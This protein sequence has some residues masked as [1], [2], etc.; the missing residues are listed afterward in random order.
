MLWPKVLG[1]LHKTHTCIII[2]V[3]MANVG[4]R[5]VGCTI[6]RTASTTLL[7]PANI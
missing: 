4:T 3:N 5:R 2:T 6:N 1:V 7:P